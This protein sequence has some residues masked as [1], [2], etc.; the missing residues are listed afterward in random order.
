MKNKIK[1]AIP[2]LFTVLSF[3]LFFSCKKD[4]NNEDAS[5]KITLQFLFEVDEETFQ[6]DTLLY[7]NAAGNLY[8]VNE[9]QF[10]ISDIYLHKSNGDSIK[11]KENN[12]IHYVDYDIPSTLLWKVKDAFSHGNYTGL[13]F[14]FGLSEEK[15]ISNSFVN[16]PESNMAWPRVLGG[17]YHYM[18]INGKWQTDSTL[19]VFHFHTGIGQI[20]EE[21]EIVDFVHNYFRV[22]LVNAPFVIS[23]NGTTIKL[24]MN[25]SN[26]FTSPNDY[27]FNYWGGGIM[28]N[29]DAQIAIKENGWNVFSIK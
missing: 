4:Q 9:I 26:W 29:Q 27:D 20:R 28:E 23:E 12:S 10:F 24:I 17:G 19:S 15:N 7:H 13:S 6:V 14:T 16:P 2:I 25:I 5:G 3:F 8:E 21:G 11:I 18:M 22:R 1:L